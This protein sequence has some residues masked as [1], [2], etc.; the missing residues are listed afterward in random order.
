MSVQWPIQAFCFKPFGLGIIMIAVGVVKGMLI[1]LYR[2]IAIY[3][4]IIKTDKLCLRCFT[5]LSLLLHSFI[6]VQ[7]FAAHNFE[8]IRSVL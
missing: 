7:C 1:K 2:H 5:V 4:M 8:N 6:I 3:V